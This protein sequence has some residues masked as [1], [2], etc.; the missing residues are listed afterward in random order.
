MERIGIET[1]K[2]ELL[3]VLPYKPVEKVDRS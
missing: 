3:R 1:L 2:S